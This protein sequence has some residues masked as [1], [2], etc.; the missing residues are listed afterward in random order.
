MKKTII[1][2]KIQFEPERKK[3]CGNESHEIETKHVHAI[4][5]DLLH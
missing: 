2:R 3:R 1:L 5:T 4:A